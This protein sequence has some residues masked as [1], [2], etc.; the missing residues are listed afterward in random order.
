MADTFIK[1]NCKI[2]FV[3]WIVPKNSVK[4][5][6][7]SN[8]AFSTCLLV[9][10]LYSITACATVTLLHSKFLIMNAYNLKYCTVYQ[11]WSNNYCNKFKI[12]WQFY[13]ENDRGKSCN[14]HN[15][16]VVRLLVGWAD[17][18]TIWHLRGSKLG[19]HSCFYN[20]DNCCHVILL[21]LIWAGHKYFFLC[22]DVNKENAEYKIKC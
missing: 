21:V 19:L 8:N 14:G 16:M 13:M 7:S 6:W 12:V 10:V 2:Y 18:P 9:F 15:S 17:C 3:L 5:Q 1:S 11:K 4:C 22:P 20:A